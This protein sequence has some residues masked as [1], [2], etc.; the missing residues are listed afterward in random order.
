MY[1]IMYKTCISFLSLNTRT[2]ILY[3]L[4]MQG[5]LL[6]K[7]SWVFWVQI[8]LPSVGFINLNPLF[9]LHRVGQ[10][11]HPSQTLLGLAHGCLFRLVGPGC[12]YHNIFV[13]S[14]PFFGLFS[15]LLWACMISRTVLQLSHGL[16]CCFRL[17]A[18][19]HRWFI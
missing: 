1:S 9:F 8:A 2:T 19:V 3:W 13:S 6:I 17:L 7:C 15:G 16:R 10:L 14:T 5:K 11:S 4:S 12:G 18:L